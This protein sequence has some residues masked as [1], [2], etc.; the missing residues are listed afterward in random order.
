MGFR[1]I[2]KPMS[3]FLALVY[4]TP[5]LGGDAVFLIKGI[6]FKPKDILF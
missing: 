2:L 4:R 5:P 1:I 3:G 6:V